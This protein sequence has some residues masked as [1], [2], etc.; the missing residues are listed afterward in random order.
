MPF[1]SLSERINMAIRRLSG[2]GRINENEIE[3]M[4]NLLKLSPLPSIMSGCLA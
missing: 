1:E 4:M 3:E 2:R